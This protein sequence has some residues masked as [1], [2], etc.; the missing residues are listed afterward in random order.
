MADKT[1]A[2][3]SFLTHLP[4]APEESEITE[5]TEIDVLSGL[6]KIPEQFM[7]LRIIYC[8]MKGL[9]EIL[10]IANAKKPI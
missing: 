5:I 4:D 8:I 7:I 6:K 9:S 10:A 2:I 3:L 1:G